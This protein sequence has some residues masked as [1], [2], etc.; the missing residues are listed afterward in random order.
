MFSDFVSFVQKKNKNKK[1]TQTNT[2]KINIINAIKAKAQKLNLWDS[3]I[4]DRLINDSIS[5]I[6]M[7]VTSAVR[8]SLVQKSTKEKRCQHFYIMPIHLLP[9]CA[10]YQGENNKLSWLSAIFSMFNRSAPQGGRIVGWLNTDSN[11]FIVYRLNLLGWQRDR[12][13]SH[14]YWRQWESLM[15]QRVMKILAFN[16]VVKNWHQN[17][18]PKQVDRI[19][20]EVD[21]LIETRS[22]VIDYK[23]V[24]IPKP[25]GKLRPLGVPTIPWR[26]YLHLWNVGLVW[27]RLTEVENKHAYVPERGVYTAWC[28]VWERINKP[29]IY[30]FDLKGFFPNV[31]LDYLEARMKQIGIPEKPE[32]I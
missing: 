31:Y 6:E 7:R 15:K 17:L 20:K 13:H 23:R 14:E 32:N 2:Q 9:N 19:L 29:N 16:Y 11:A 12:G 1:V 10:S 25:T 8:S 28:S 26:I 3:D 4:R 27:Y 24:Y 22:Q 21:E 30:E 5:S 18:D